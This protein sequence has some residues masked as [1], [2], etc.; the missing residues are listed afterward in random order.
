MR[1][2]LEAL[3]R[4]CREGVIDDEMRFMLGWYHRIGDFALLRTPGLPAVE[5]V[6]RS[7]DPHAWEEASLGDG[8]MADRGLLG[9]YWSSLA[10]RDG[11]GRTGT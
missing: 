1:G 6:A 5:A 2:T 4:A 7:G 11:E 8:R 9:R 3:D 10:R